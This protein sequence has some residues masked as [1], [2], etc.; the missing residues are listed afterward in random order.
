MTTIVAGI[1]ALLMVIGGIVP[2]FSNKSFEDSLKVVL[3][4]PEKVQ[5]KVYSTPSYKILGGN[6]DRIEI[7]VSKPKFANFEFDEL[8]I[9]TYPVHLDYSKMANSKDL[10]FIKEGKLESLLVLSTEALEKALNIP[11]LTVRINNF[12]ANF[13]L[14]LPMLSGGVSVDNLT[15]IFENNQPSLTGNLVALGGFFTAPFTLTGELLVTEK[16]TIELH[17]P[18][19][20]VMEQP[21]VIEQIQDLVKFINPILDINKFNTSERNFQLNKLFFKDNKLK[22]MGTISFKNL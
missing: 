11:S 14:P 2:Q 10:K 13:R 20:K 8:S 21:L 4:N 3:N 9:V 7:N 1:L 6:F 19:I 15:L 17:K 5:V 12:L 18:Q 16:N 22:L